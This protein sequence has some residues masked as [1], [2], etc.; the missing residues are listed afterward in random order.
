MLDMNIPAI[1][2]INGNK[3]KTLFPLAPIPSGIRLKKKKTKEIRRII[4]LLSTK[5]RLYRFIIVFKIKKIR[6]TKNK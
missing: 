4:R 2:A 5:D 3:T 6:D 1:M